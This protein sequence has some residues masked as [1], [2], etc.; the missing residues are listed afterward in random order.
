[1]FGFRVT[2]YRSVYYLPVG[3]MGNSVP[4]IEVHRR[5]GGVS[6]AW[7]PLPCVGYDPILLSLVHVPPFDPAPA[8][9]GV[10]ADG[11]TPPLPNH[12]LRE[13]KRPSSP[14]HNHNRMRLSLVSVWS[15]LESYETR[16]GGGST[17]LD[18]KGVRFPGRTLDRA[19]TC[20]AFRSH[21]HARRRRARRRKK[22][23]KVPGRGAEEE[24]KR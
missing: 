6:T 23:L 20:S 17:G 3:C 12:P 4:H 7:S 24:G 15:V 2:S 16:V 19:A 8:P 11:C 14:T 5:W 18:E 9:T 22:H 10:L 21:L 13:W 1:M